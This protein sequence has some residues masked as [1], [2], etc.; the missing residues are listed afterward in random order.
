[1]L[2]IPTLWLMIAVFEYFGVLDQDSPGW[3]Q[4]IGSIGAVFAA[5][6][7]A[8][9]QSRQRAIEQRNRGLVVSRLVVGVATRAAGVSSLLFHSYNDLMRKVD[10]TNEEILTLLESQVLALRGINPVDLPHPDMVEPFLKIRGA[11]EQ[12]NVMAGLLV[13]ARDGHFDHLRCAT[14]FSHNSQAVAIAAQE[15]ER[16]ANG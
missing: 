9:H 8:T 3:I 2:G 12:S 13:R 4:A 15:L 14:V 11:M 7:I 1:M 6:F 10:E 5:V 16:I